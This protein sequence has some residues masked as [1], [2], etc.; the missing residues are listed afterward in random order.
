[1]A[2]RVATARADDGLRRAVVD[3]IRA[4]GAS[5]S[6]RRCDCNSAR[7]DNTVRL[8]YDKIERLR[9]DEQ[10]DPGPALSRSVPD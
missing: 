4:K 9:C 5:Q 8:H 1:M 7:C 10:G 3:R 2:F 6:Q